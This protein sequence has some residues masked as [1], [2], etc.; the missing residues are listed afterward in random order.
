MAGA[1]A[2]LTYRPPAFLTAAAA[3]AVLMAVL[4]AV[5]AAG[6][7]GWALLRSLLFS[8]V[9]AVVTLLVNGTQQIFGSTAKLKGTS[10]MARLLRRHPE[11]RQRAN[12]RGLSSPAGATATAR[13]TSTMPK[14]PVTTTSR[15][16]NGKPSSTTPGSIRSMATA[17]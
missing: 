5:L 9:A 4:A 13:Q 17:A 12:L 6:L 7:S 16:G 11:K 10:D 14:C 3:V 2:L 15:N 1:R 8:A